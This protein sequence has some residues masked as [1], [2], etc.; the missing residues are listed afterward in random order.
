LQVVE[1]QVIFKQVVEVGVDSE[2]LY[3]A[4]LLGLLVLS[5]I[6]VILYQFLFK[7]TLSL[8]VAVVQEEVLL[9]A[10]VH[11]VP[12]QFLVQSHQQEAVQVDQVVQQVL[13]QVEQ[14]V[15][16]EAVEKIIMAEQEILL[17]YLPLKETMV[18]MVLYLTSLVEVVVEQVLQGLPL[19]LIQ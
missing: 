16:V 2:N 10:V 18:E 14:V 3:L 1:V 8:L 13:F 9:P 17:Q 11:K 12:I 19:P 6:P 15:L 7:G 5:L 4:L